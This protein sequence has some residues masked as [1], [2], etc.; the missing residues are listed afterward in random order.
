MQNHGKITN[1]WEI[2]LQNL[3]R[4]KEV[5]NWK[6]LGKWTWFQEI[7][8]C[9]PLWCSMDIEI[10]HTNTVVQAQNVTVDNKWLD[11]HLS[12]ST[13]ESD[14]TTDTYDTTRFYRVAFQ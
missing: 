2:K 13:S 7:M 4:Q 10:L 12:Q 11:N 5:C 6:K 9:T 3:K 14:T 8:D 1:Y